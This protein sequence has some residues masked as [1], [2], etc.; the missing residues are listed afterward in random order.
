MGISTIDLFADD[1]E[2]KENEAEEGIFSVLFDDPSFL[3]YF[4]CGIIIFCL[5]LAVISY[6]LSICKMKN[7]KAETNDVYLKEIKTVSSTS[8]SFPDL[9]L[10]MSVQSV[11]VVS[12]QGQIIDGAAP[13]YPRVVSIPYSISE[14]DPNFVGLSN[15]SSF[16]SLHNIQSPKELKQVPEI[17][18]LPKP[19]VSP[20]NDTEVLYGD[21]F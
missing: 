5:A 10:Q 3:I 11:S 8:P 21:A 19:P 16:Q 20:S 17:R 6:A 12:M 15:V 9:K 7:K 4:A 18:Q 14:I 13:S 1:E 2:K